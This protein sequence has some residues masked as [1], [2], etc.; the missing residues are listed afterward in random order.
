MR[1]FPTKTANST[2]RAAASACTGRLQR[3]VEVFVEVRRALKPMAP[4][5]LSFSNRCFPTKA[6]ALWLQTDDA[7]HMQLVT[8]YF[9]M[10]GGWRGIAVRS[11]HAPASETRS[12][13]CGRMR[14]G[15]P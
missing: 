14:N 3:P 15:D 7:G 4:F 12:T 5:V 10:S 6:V 13:P 9:E 8:R 1:R 11:G 2:R